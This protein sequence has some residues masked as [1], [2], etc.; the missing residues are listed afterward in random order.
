MSSMECYLS[1][2]NIN[3][4]IKEEIITLQSCAELLYGQPCE[5]S[6][7]SREDVL[8]A[9]MDIIIL[10]IDIDNIPDIVD[11]SVGLCE[12]VRMIVDRHYHSVFESKEEF[13]IHI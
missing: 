13:V 10:E 8:S 9:I 5:Y 11:Y 4:G 1:I 6:G 7:M 12:F 2:E 3:K